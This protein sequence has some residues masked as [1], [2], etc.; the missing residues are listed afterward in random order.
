MDGIRRLS[1]GTDLS[2]RLTLALD[3]TSLLSKVIGVSGDLYVVIAVDVAVVVIIVVH[4]ATY[5]GVDDKI[6]S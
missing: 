4:L 6:R 3:S 5:R 2:L 1:S